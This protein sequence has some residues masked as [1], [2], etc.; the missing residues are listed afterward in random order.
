[1]FFLKMFITTAFRNHRHNLATQPVDRCAAVY[2]A[3]GVPLTDR[4]DH[5]SEP[6]GCVPVTKF[7]FSSQDGRVSTAIA[8]AGKLLILTVPKKVRLVVP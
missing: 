2:E 6:G 5:R 3:S 1:M 8:V 4:S 7:S